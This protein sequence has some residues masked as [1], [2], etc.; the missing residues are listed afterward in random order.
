M[1]LEFLCHYF[2]MNSSF[3]IENDLMSKRMYIVLLNII[4]L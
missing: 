2:N 3:N 4:F 1:F